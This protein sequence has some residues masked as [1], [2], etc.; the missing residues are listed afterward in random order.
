MKQ[1]AP[2]RNGEFPDLRIVPIDDLLLHEEVDLER[3]ARLI[4][5]LSS[6]GVIRNPPIVAS[7]NDSH[8]Y[9]LLDGSNRISALQN[10]EVPHVLV[11]VEPYEQADL[12]VSHWNHVV[13]D[14]EAKTMIEKAK[15]IPGVSVEE[16]EP[17]A[18]SAMDRGGY[19]CSI[20]LDESKALHLITGN[21]LIERVR[22]LRE[23]THIYY[24]GPARMDRVNHADFETIRRH[25]PHF[26]AVILFPDF[27]KAEIREIAEAGHRLPSGVTRILV[28]RR[29]LGFNLQLAL[30]KSHLSLEEKRHWLEEAINEKV[31]ERK[32]RY[33]QEPTF[34]F[35][36]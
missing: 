21:E 7:L 6:D 35:D 2:R 28:P 14:I 13:R 34:V 26:G 33:Y 24:R 19:F 15:T 11:Q 8:R 1:T 31:T 10:L 18:A 9:L 4:D 12:V 16:A 27:S 17:G 23:L 30:L 25:H 36:D 32:V 20:A 3:V 5:R 22:Y 29:V